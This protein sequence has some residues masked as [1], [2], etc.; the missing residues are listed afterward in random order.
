MAKKEKK[1]GLFL[2]QTAKIVDPIINR[3]LNLCVGKKF[4]G[5][6]KYQINTGGKRIRPALAIASAKLFGGKTRDVLYPAAGL[7]IL[8]NYSLIID[9]IIDNSFLRRGKPTVWAKF[10]RS[11]AQCIGIDFGAA[12]FQAANR[13]RYP[14]K[15][16]EILAKTLKILVEGEISD[17]LFEQSGRKDEPYVVKN[18][19][20]NVSEKRYLEMVGKKTA[21]LFQSCCEIGAVSAGAKEKQIK[22][23]KNYGFNLGVAFQVKDDILDIFGEGQKF[24]KKIGKDIQEG[25]MANAIICFAYQEFSQKEKKEFS[26]IIRKGV[27]SDRDIRRAIILIKK[28]KAREKAINYGE[29]FIEKAKANLSLLPKN[30]WNRALVDLCDIV[31]E[32]EN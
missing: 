10:G 16:S 1:V 23:L 6:V 31:I 27:I 2:A 9:D 26:Q 5:M 29:R 30:S 28:T 20:R 17:I 18:R 12:I 22:A 7:E 13:S 32:R 4:Q 3:L 15:T 21:S 14:V 11:I 19:Y 24:G 8:H 25:K